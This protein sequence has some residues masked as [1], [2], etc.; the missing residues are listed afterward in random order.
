MSSAPGRRLLRFSQPNGCRR[1]RALE[2]AEPRA[3][4]EANRKSGPNVRLLGYSDVTGYCTTAV[5]RDPNESG[6][7]IVHQAEAGSA[8]LSSK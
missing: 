4:A 3:L 6:W 1:W 5:A 8:T 7:I 2:I